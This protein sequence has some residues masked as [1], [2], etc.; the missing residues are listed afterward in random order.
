MG[1]KKY[2]EI[3]NLLVIITHYNTWGIESRCLQLFVS[4]S[5]WA[6]TILTDYYC[7]VVHSYTV[8]AK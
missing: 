8:A 1:K 5:Q 2:S 3:E 6:R 7:V 4:D